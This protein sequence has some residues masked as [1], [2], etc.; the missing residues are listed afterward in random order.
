[1]LCRRERTADPRLTV[2]DLFAGE[3]EVIVR[4]GRLARE[5]RRR[6]RDLVERV[7]R[8]TGAVPSWPEAD[9]A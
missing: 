5:D 7:D 3:D 9:S 2:V 4:D 6:R 8:E 1:V